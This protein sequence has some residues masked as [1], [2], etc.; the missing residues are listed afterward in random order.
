M[1]HSYASNL[2]Q[3]G[4]LEYDSVVE[5]VSKLCE[6]SDGAL[7]CNDDVSL[8]CKVIR[9]KCC[10]SIANSVLKVQELR[11]EVV[12]II[13]DDIESKS[14]KQEQRVHG[15]VSTLMQKSFSDLKAFKWSKIVD[16]MA[17]LYPELVNILVKLMLK[18]EKKCELSSVNAII[19][20]LGLIYAVLLQNK[21]AKQSTESNYYVL[22]IPYL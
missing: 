18:H 22:G 2:D 5:S 1:D 16:E 7:I 20:K 6:K 9:T 15:N 13:S 14:Q 17:T 3:S 11:R 4:T 19:P 8:L 21:K 10:T 12:N